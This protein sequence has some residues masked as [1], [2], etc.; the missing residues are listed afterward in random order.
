MIEDDR[1]GPPIPWSEDA[2]YTASYCEENVYLL[3]AHY[4]AMTHG[5]IYVAFVSNP[6]KSVSL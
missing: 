4:I 6:N 2:Y 5:A 3:V 1:Y